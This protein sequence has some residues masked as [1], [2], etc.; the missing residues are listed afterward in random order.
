MDARV[1]KDY[2]ELLVAVRKSMDAYLST[3]EEYLIKREF[4][5]VAC[6]AG[7]LTS[8]INNL[9]NIVAAHADREPD[10]KDAFEVSSLVSTLDWLSRD[11][12]CLKDFKG[13]QL[14]LPATAFNGTYP[15][16]AVPGDI[17]YPA[18][19]IMLKSAAAEIVLEGNVVDLSAK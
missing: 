11:D 5:G 1:L 4:P 7:S 19:M 2:T 14:T 12:Y 18:A 3:G 10:K 6:A 16:V 9:K 8:R 17:E 15:D 13:I